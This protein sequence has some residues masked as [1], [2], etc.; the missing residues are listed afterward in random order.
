MQ[1]WLTDKA[2]IERDF[3]GPKGGV[4]FEKNGVVELN[5]EDFKQATNEFEFL[6]I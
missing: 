1:S 2:I 5:Y 3:T 6:Y 4:Y